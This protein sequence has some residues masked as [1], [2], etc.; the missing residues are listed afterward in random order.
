MKARHLSR[1]LP[2][3]VQTGSFSDANSDLTD[4]GNE[5][6]SYVRTSVLI[7]H[8]ADGLIAIKSYHS[9]RVGEGIVF[10][11]GFKPGQI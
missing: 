1:I 10:A 4:F 6:R 9:I 5:G 2:C 3:A 11:L 8:K 7:F